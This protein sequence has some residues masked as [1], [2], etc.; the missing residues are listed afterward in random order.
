MPL[1]QMLYSLPP[2]LTATLLAGVGLT[3]L[4]RGRRAPAGRFWALLCLLGTMLYVDMLVDFNASRASVALATTRAAHLFYPFLLPL[5][6]QFFHT[7]LGIRGR[8]LLERFAYGYA[9]LIAVCTACG[10][11]ISGVHRFKF[12]FFGQSGSLF[13]LLAAGAALATLYNGIIIYQAILQENRSI[14]KNKLKYIFCGF[15]LLGA[16]CSSNCLTVLGVPIYPPGAFGFIPLLV[17][18]AG[19]FRYDLLDMGVLLRNSL[20]CA[21]LTA[22]L[23]AGFLALVIPLQHLFKTSGLIESPLFPL[24][25]LILI[26]L[27][28]GLLKNISSQTSE[29]FL[30]KDRYDFRRTLRRV[31]QTIAMVLDEEKI[32]HLLREIII[33]VMKV[34]SCALFLMD[35]AGGHY[36][37][38]ASAGET[39]VS[40]G[41]I[42]V[43]DTLFVRCLRRS[44]RSLMKQQLLGAVGRKQADA[45]LNEFEAVGGEVI[46]PMRFKETLKGFLVLGEKRS[47]E[48]YAAQDLDLLEPLCY[49]S[50]VAIQNAHAYQALKTLNR[51]LEMKVAERT[52]DLRL[53]LAEK[54]RSQEQLIRSESLAALGQ[55]VAGVAHELNNPLT[56]V[57]SLLQSALEDLQLCDADHPVDDVLMDDLRFADKEL[58]RAKAIVAS[59]LG[60]SRQTQTYEEAV[61]LNLV[62]RDTLRVLH[63]QYK[64]TSLNII[65]RLSDDLPA[66]QGNFAN[67]G[68]VILNVVQNAVQA[69]G[70]G[71][72]IILTTRYDPGLRQ[73]VFSC[74]DNGPGIEPAERRNVFKPFFTTKPVGQGTG[75]GLYICHQ[76]VEKH[77]GTIDLASAEPHGAIVTVKLPLGSSSANTANDQ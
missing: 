50:A 25:I 7:Y 4:G 24:S 42:L 39:V 16:L 41:D 30:S 28:Y 64:Y 12:G 48:M 70:A 71:G 60:L 57:T 66:L 23:I 53:A 35:P 26:V 73:V 38:V 8:S 19:L 33:D 56:S 5:F 72:E 1:Q 11:I 68:Q 32:T 49:Q 18:A 13:I 15:G 76:I 54:E 69:A 31:S 20:I 21:V 43:S 44:E 74:E 14:Q 3:A 77:H 9:V 67:L 58:A 45:L 40:Q 10:W 36:Y 22:L 2:F 51:T 34:K 75:L 63:N 59:L 62:V 29:R 37:A 47:G 27:C 65:D 55:L 52:K 17:F 61:D 6:I 46:L